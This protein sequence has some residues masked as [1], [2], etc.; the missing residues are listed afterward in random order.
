MDKQT[1]VWCAELVFM[2]VALSTAIAA[3]TLGDVALG[4]ALVALAGSTLALR[5]QARRP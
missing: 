5:R 3:L 4:I 1:A 2:V